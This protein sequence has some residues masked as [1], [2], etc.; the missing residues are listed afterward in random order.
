M[1]T[2]RNFLLTLVSGVVIFLLGMISMHILSKRQKSVSLSDRLIAFADGFLISRALYVVAELNIADTLVDGPKTAQEIAEKLTLNRDAVLRLLRMLAGHGVFN[3]NDDGSFA[4]NDLSKLLTT[5]HPHSLHGFLLHEDEARWQ[6]YGSMTYTLKTG[7]PAFNH[8]FGE[9]YFDYIARDKKRS[10]QFDRGMATLSEAENKQIAHAV[11]FLPYHRIV[12][13][14]G[15]VGGLLAAIMHKNP[16]IHAVLY[17]LPHLQPLAEKYIFERGLGN[18]IEIATGSFLETVVSGGDLYILKR[19]LHDWNDE[20][21]LKILRNCHKA[22]D[23]YARLVVRSFDK[24]FKAN[25]GKQ[26][27]ISKDIDII[28]MVIFGGKERTQKDFEKLF[29]ASGFKLDKITS[30]PGSMLS[31]IEIVKR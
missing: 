10:E 1:I 8:L 22:M 14:G 25:E 31:A 13:V 27:D 29:E 2:V 30:I 16:D 26:Y 6:A 11:N 5:S 24:S 3:Q 28:M 4:L 12:D 9:G 20:I 18:R 7:K 19:I 23:H 17:E 21:C 15:G